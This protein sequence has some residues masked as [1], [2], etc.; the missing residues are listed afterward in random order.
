MTKSDVI[1]HFGGT[2]KA[3]NALNLTKGAVSLWDEE[4]PLKTQCYIEVA[5]NRALKADRKQLKAN[6][7]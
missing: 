7:A 1:A 5:T 3:A 6:R 2:V 4:L